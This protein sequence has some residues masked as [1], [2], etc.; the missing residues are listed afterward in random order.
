MFIII[1][2]MTGK[3]NEIYPIFS[4]TFPFPGSLFCRPVVGRNSR[5]TSFNEKRVL[6]ESFSQLHC[7]SSSCIVAERSF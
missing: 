7:P 5:K 6:A 4:L 2:Y 3:R 1:W